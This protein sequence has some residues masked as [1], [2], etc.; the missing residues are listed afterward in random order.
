MG[1]FNALARVE[2]RKALGENPWFWLSLAAGC[3]LALFSAYEDSIVFNNTLDLALEYWDESDVLYSAAS[4]FHFWMLVNSYELASGI[5][6]MVWPLLAALPYAWSWHAEIKSGLLDQ[7]YARADR[8]ACL[9][10]KLLATFYSGAVAVA[11][12]AL[13]SLIACACFAPA[14]P[15]W[16]SDL[17]YVGV[18]SS[19]PLSQL[20]YSAP[21][22]FCLV[23]TLIVGCVAGL[24]ATTVASLAVL[25]RSFLQ[26]AVA[27]Y[28]VLH[29]LSFLGSQAHTLL[30]GV[31]PDEIQLSALTG[32]DV[33]RVV[34]V[35]SEPGQTQLLLFVLVT[36]T[37]FSG[38]VFVL[39]RRR[40][41]L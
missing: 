19:A 34:F 25:M 12:P 30:Y 38:V 5:F 20:F 18:T 29:V 22:A 2:L 15:V 4:C 37:A 11:L 16:V 13:V 41:C 40:D 8:R 17:I 1:R 6:R 39:R 28:L 32:L 36:L 3:A 10:A 31:L 7:Q 26:A 27:S 21:L 14:T 33:F 35:V 9:A 23:W 24:W